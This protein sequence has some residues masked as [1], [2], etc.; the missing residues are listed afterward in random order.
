MTVKCTFCND[1][2]QE[3]GFPGICVWCEDL[4]AIPKYEDVV[5]QLEAANKV[6]RIISATLPHLEAKNT[7]SVR[8]LIKDINVVIGSPKEANENA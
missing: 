7:D 6:L 4:A 2:K 1:T 8:Q 5:A 3:P